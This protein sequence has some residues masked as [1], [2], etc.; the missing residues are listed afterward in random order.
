MSAAKQGK[1]IYTEIHSFCSILATIAS[2]RAQNHSM[3]VTNLTVEFNPNSEQ[4]AFSESFAK[5]YS[6]HE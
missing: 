3:T 6:T 1:H 4:V 2:M 5:K